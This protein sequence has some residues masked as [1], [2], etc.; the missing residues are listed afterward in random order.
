MLRSGAQ[1]LA[2][3]LLSGRPAL[4][5]RHSEGALVRHS[6]QELQGAPSCLG[7][8]FFCASERLSRLSSSYL[9]KAVLDVHLAKNNGRHPV[10]HPCHFRREMA[11]PRLP[12]AA[13]PLG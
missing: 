9:L 11:E 12:Q 5:S 8:P 6:S 10:G 4:Y 3:A 7:L 1:K 13:T 2:K